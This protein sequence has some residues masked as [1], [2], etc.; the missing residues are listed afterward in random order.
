MQGFQ[1]CFHALPPL[2]LRFQLSGRVKAAHFDVD[3]GVE[4]DSSLLLGIV[5]HGYGN[6]EL[7]K[8]DPDLKLADKVKVDDHLKF[9]SRSGIL[10]EML[11]L[12][13]QFTYDH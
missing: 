8:S 3:W 4:E 9:L 10:L 5:E 6:W 13:G 7:I 12:T 11:P 2:Y 1:C